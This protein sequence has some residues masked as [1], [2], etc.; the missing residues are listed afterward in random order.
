MKKLLSIVTLLVLLAGSAFAAER[1]IKVSQKVEEGKLPQTIV[2]NYDA[3]SLVTKKFDKETMTNYF[4][5]IFTNKNGTI[6]QCKAVGKNAEI[7]AVVEKDIPENVLAAMF[8][9]DFD[10]TWNMMRDL[11]VEE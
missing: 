3:D 10:R 2:S 5:T 1:K 6:V 9:M 11:E 7:F 8:V 4:V